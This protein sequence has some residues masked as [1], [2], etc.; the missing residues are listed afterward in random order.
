M[1][2]GAA[3]QGVVLL[4][5]DNPMNLGVLF[6]S[7]NGSGFKLL[8]AQDGE[9]AIAQVMYRKPDIILLDV[10]M[11]GI[12]GFETCRRLKENPK[13][14]DIPIIFMTA[15]TETVDKVRGFG[16]G[17]VDYITKPFQMEEVIARI[18]AHLAVQQLQ[19]QLAEQNRKLQAEICDR[20]Q[21]EQSLR[22][23]LHAVSHDLRNPVTGLLMVLKNLLSAS[24]AVD[25]SQSGSNP[26]STDAI[27]IPRH[28]LERMIE[29][30]DRQLKLINSLL[31]AHTIDTQGIC[32]NQE[33]IQFGAL[34][35]NILHDLQPILD[36]NKATLHSQIPTNLPLIQG[37]SNQLWRVLENLIFNAL[38]HNPPGLTL[39]VML[40][41]EGDRL[42]CCVQD[43]GVGIDTDQAGKLF[44]LYRRG[45]NARHTHGLGLGLYLCRQIV[46]AHGGNIGVDS[47]P[48]QGSTFWFTLPI[49]TPGTANNTL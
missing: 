29:S 39:T 5:D 40:T 49:A 42:R 36:K 4:V 33:V 26:C 35:Q 1:S 6:E 45:S 12:D 10:M 2:V 30:G 47:A 37:D 44:D 34:L 7:L 38:K 41:Q 13:T 11:P 19:N 48:G 21:A 8:A 9:S 46:L 23:L 25:C 32:L 17:A 16:L 18:K 15:L 24:T 20:E 43:N 22:V 28:I 14:R 31:E 27:M 3:E